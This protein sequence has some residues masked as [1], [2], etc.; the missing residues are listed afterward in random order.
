MLAARRVAGSALPR[1]ASQRGGTASAA[2]QL[3]RRCQSTLSAEDTEALKG[4]PTV[5]VG[6]LFPDAS[7]DRRDAAHAELRQALVDEDAPGFFYALNAPEQLNAK[8]L[9]SVYA[10]VED[11]QKRVEGDPVRLKAAAQLADALVENGAGAEAEATGREAV[12][13]HGRAWVLARWQRQA[14][15][16]SRR[17]AGCLVGAL[18][19]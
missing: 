8:Y 1:K 4:F 19:I 2:A 13:G 5:D 12:R 6:G 14:V 15:R 17:R 18:A 10:F 3:A 9:D 16:C 11:A 7:S